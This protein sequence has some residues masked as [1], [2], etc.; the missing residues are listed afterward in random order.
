M[1]IYV[2]ICMYTCECVGG[3]DWT[4]RTSLTRSSRKKEKR[5]SHLAS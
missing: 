1:Y 2:Y 5:S 4:S 3:G